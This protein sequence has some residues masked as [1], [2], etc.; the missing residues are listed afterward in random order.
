MRRVEVVS[1]ELLFEVLDAFPKLSVSRGFPDVV[2]DADRPLEDVELDLAGCDSASFPGGGRVGL[3]DDPVGVVPNELVVPV[4]RVAV[5]VLLVLVVVVPRESPPGIPGPCGR[6]WDGRSC[7]CCRC[8]LFLE[9]QG[10]EGGHGW[11]GEPSVPRVAAERRRLAHIVVG[12]V[13][14]YGRMIDNRIG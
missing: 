3:D 6:A 7:R 14:C 2:L 12:G 9:G 10:L 8:G 1:Q 4:V 5:A 11:E 13:S